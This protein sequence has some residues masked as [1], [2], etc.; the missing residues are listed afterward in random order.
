M[1]QLLAATTHVD[2]GFIA[3]SIIW[4]LIYYVCTALGMYG[5]FTKAG[6]YGQPKWAAFIPLYRFIIMLR[7][8]GRPR[9]WGW[10]L[11]LYLLG[12]IPLIGLVASIGLLIVSIFVLNDISKSFGHGAG[13]TVG[14]VLLPFIFWLILW[15]GPSTYRGPAGPEGGGQPGGLA[16]LRR[17]LRPGTRLS[18][19]AT[20]LSPAGRVPPSGPAAPAHARL[21]AAATPGPTAA[22]RADAPAPVVE[23]AAAGSFSRSAPPGPAGRRG[24]PPGSRGWLRPE[25]GP[26]GHRARAPPWHRHRVRG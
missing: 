8:A 25:P 3:A 14:L 18:P 7:V 2:G 10:F 19:A 6:S 15:L 21:S 11:L 22:A 9:I 17:W 5:A 1:G 12:A 13:F 23:G 4:F 24:R 26:I 16:W 20:R